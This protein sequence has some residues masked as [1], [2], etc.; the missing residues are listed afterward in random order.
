[1]DDTISRCQKSFHAM[2]IPRFVP[3]TVF[4]FG[5]AVTEVRDITFV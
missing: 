4:D 5:Y 3:H 2:D 1:M